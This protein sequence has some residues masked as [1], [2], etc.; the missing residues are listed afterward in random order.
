V[1]SRLGVEHAYANEN[2]NEQYVNVG[3]S[4]IMLNYFLNYACNNGEKCNSQVSLNE[5]K[6]KQN[7]YELIPD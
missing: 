7:D 6:M 3:D 5:S 4:M 1:L 2:Y